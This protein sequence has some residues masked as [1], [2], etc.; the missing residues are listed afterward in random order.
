MNGFALNPSSD[1]NLFKRRSSLFKPTL[2]D[3]DV[4]KPSLSTFI[5]S[6]REQEFT[7]SNVPITWE[8]LSTG[9]RIVD[10]QVDRTEELLELL[11]VLK[12]CVT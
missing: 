11:K 10:F 6:H 8:R 1:I 12:N 5:Q 7:V 9:Y 3:D 4:L 2:E